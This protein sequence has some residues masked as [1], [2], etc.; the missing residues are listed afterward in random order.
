MLQ[1]QVQR[2]DGLDLLAAAIAK[3]SARKLFAEPHGG[4]PGNGALQRQEIFKGLRSSLQV[5]EA[6]TDALLRVNQLLY[7]MM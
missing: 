5:S 2:Q 7:D 6:E 3:T 4:L 1:N